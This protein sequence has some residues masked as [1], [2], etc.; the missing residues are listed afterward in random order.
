MP[1][2][3]DLAALSALQGR[4]TTGMRRVDY[5]VHQGKPNPVH[6]KIHLVGSVPAVLLKVYFDTEEA[7]IAACREAG[8]QNL[9]GVDCRFVLRD[10]K[11]V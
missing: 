10:G 5:P 6:G 7:C 8:V 1:I 3:S 4:M 2:R 9:Q 11:S